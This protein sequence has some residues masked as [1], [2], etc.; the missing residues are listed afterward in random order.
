LKQS[1][2]GIETSQDC[3]VPSGYSININV[4]IPANDTYNV[5]INSENYC[6]NPGSGCAMDHAIFMNIP[7]VS[8]STYNVNLSGDSTS[9]LD[10][11]P[12][13]GIF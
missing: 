4:I 3:T 1:I 9:K 8:G 6:C 10:S 13:S 5:F 11:I 7:L 2:T 12:S